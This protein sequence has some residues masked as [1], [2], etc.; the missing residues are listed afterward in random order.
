M[1]NLMLKKLALALTGIYFAFFTLSIA[2]ANDSSPYN[3]DLKIYKVPFFLQKDDNKLFDLIL[4]AESAD[5]QGEITS[6]NVHYTMQSNLELVADL[7]AVDDSGTILQTGHH[8]KNEHFLSLPFRLKLKPGRQTI[9][10]LFSGNALEAL[11]TGIEIDRI[12]I[13]FADKTIVRV[14]AEPGYI[15]RPAT[16]LRAAGQ[17]DCD[18]Y[19]IPGLV[20]TNSGAL[21]AVYDNRYNN[22]KDLQENIDIGMSRSIDGGQNWEPMKV[23]VDMGEWGGQ[24]ESL[25]GIGD[26]CILYDKKNATI[27]VAALWM[28]GGTEND[29]LWWISKPGMI[30]AETGQF[31]LAKSTDD[32]LTWS[33]P[34]NITDQIKDPSWQLLLQ[35]PGRGICMKNGTLVFPAQFKKNVGE[36]SLDGGQFTC[37]STLVYSTDGGQHWEI[38]SGAKTNTTEAQVAELSDGS[39]M[40]NMRDDRNRTD[41]SENNGRAV[42]VTHDLGQTWETHPT[43]NSSLPEPNCM[44]SLI[45]TEI[46]VNG[47]KKH[48]LF[49]SNPNNKFERT[50][51]TIKASLDDGLTWPELYQ[52]ELNETGG[53]GYSCMSMVDENTIGI[54]YEGVKDIYFQKIP[55]SDFFRVTE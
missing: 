40:L 12:E 26:P 3:F 11:S 52:I 15:H 31:M 4:T 53:Y 36:K 14:D 39:L 55:V 48:V 28:S 34:I 37:H 45:S 46:L 20:T 27:W 18:T 43:S 7:K 1:K 6:I 13:V 30:P 17:D 9:S 47:S 42:A 21:I 38:G 41:K 10:F 22:S 50:N 35:G 19:R 5:I 25:N 29:M 23:I 8:I 54:L 49:F 33:A 44:A 2:V 51:M 32:G 24:P 16:V